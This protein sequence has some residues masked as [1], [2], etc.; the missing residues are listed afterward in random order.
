MASQGLK[1]NENRRRH[2]SKL[3]CHEAEAFTILEAEDSTL[4]NLEAEAKAEDGLFVENQIQKDWLQSQSFGKPQSRSLWRSRSR[5]QAIK[6][7]GSWS[8]DP[9]KS[10]LRPMSEQ[11]MT[12]QRELRSANGCRCM[13]TLLHLQPGYAIRE[14]SLCI[15]PRLIVYTRCRCSRVAVHL[16]SFVLLSL[17]YDISSRLHCQLL[18]TLITFYHHKATHNQCICT[19]CPFPNASRRKWGGVCGIIF[20]KL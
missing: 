11:E 20:H 7:L 18:S 9:K 3:R 4:V 1:R 12:S 10:R 16:Y 8:L 5:S 17:L 6:N 14:G 13:S 19:F 15:P 2:G